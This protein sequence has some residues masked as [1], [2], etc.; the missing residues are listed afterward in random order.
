[1]TETKRVSCK[2]TSFVHD[3][4]SNTY[5]D[6]V[7]GLLNPESKSAATFAE[8]NGARAIHKA[9]QK[10]PDLHTLLKEASA[11]AL[12]VD[13]FSLTP[14]QIDQ[15]AL[16]V[17][18]ADAYEP[19]ADFEPDLGSV[20]GIMGGQERW[21]DG[22]TDDRE[23]DDERE[24]DEDFEPSLGSRNPQITNNLYQ[25]KGR[26][27]TGAYLIP[28]SLSQETWAAGGCD[29]LE[30]DPAELGEE[31]ERGFANPDDPCSDV[32]A[33]GGRNV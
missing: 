32:F 24:P 2:R 33:K 3:E 5:S 1:M 22:N 8:V 21:A 27:Y 6:S 9:K 4:D 28:S 15:L 12:Q 20:E 13:V 19:D 30:H 18:I 7:N 11:I 17:Y 26:I 31:D 25:P 16:L 23:L 29:D 14:E 10:A